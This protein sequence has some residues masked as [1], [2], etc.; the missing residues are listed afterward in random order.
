MH[1]RILRPLLSLHKA[2]LVEVCRSAG[3]SW[4]EDPTNTNTAYARNKMREVLGRQH[5]EPSLAPLQT[6]GKA[7][8]V[9]KEV[10]GGKEAD[11]TTGR[12]GQPDQEITCANSGEMSSSDER[13]DPTA[14]SLSGSNHAAEEMKVKQRSGV[15]VTADVLKLVDACSEASAI[16]T[17]RVSAVRKA[18]VFDAAE[19]WSECFVNTAMLLSSSK[20]IAVRALAGILQV[21]PRTPIY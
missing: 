5:S 18:A 17:G 12:T 1:G 8:A 9:S 20:H 16:V 13:Q 11:F 19:D 15:S 7:E 4:A 14:E 21:I 2:D 6:S 10:S 3:L